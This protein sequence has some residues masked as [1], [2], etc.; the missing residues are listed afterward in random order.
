MRKTTQGLLLA[1]S[2]AAPC[3]AAAQDEALNQY[4]TLLRETQGLRAYNALLERQIA[5]QERQLVDLQAAIEAVPSLERQV[6]PLIE[7]MVEGLEQFIALDIPFLVNERN[8]RLATLQTLVENADVSDAE[9]FRRVLEAWE[10]E[11]EYG[12][13]VSAYTGTLNIDGVDTQVDFLRVGRIGAWDPREG[14][15]VAL[16]SQ[17]RNSIR[18]AIRMARNSVAPDIVLLPITPPTLE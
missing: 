8:D 1:L 5:T 15:F 10:I 12:R 17:H 16:G 6:P 18:Q 14:Q 11:N 7:R 4:D 13:D 9:K 3:L 2:I